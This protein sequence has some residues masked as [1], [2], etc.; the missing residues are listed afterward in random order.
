MTQQ[1][2]VI[3]D[4]DYGDV[5]IERAIIEGAGLRLAAADCKTEDDVIEA[6]HDADAII[7]Q[8]A[9]VGARA[10]D[11]LT[12]C[13]VIARYGTGVDIVDVD[14]A[15]RRGILVTNVPSD[16]CENEVADHAMALLLAAARKVCEY[17]RATRAGTWRWQTGEPVHRLRGRTAGLLGFGAIAR[18]IAVRAHAFGMLVIAHDPYLTP[19]DVAVH[20]AT[21]VSF[22]ELLEQADYLVIQAPLTE[23]TRHLIGEPELRRMKPTSILVNTARGPIVEDKALYAALTG[24]WIVGAGLDD[25]EEE[26]AKQR[27]WVP[28][29]PL[30][31]LDNVI[32]T[33]HAAYYSAEA[34][35]T[36]REFAAHEVT[37]VLTGKPPLSPVN[38]A[39][40]AIVHR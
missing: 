14:A 29:N 16:W 17:D 18:A 40:L 10:I 1:T 5:D 19:E 39:E 9:T 11:A 2:V 6:A 34:I 15:T 37:R 12:R 23:E 7:A 26:P 27:D 4:Y 20:G 8:Y 25:L 35:H 22:G 32:I 24:G 28:V 38:A 13:K 36:V 31:S 3:A 30:F 21:A 33:P